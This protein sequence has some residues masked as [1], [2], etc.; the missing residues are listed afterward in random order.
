MLGVGL[1]DVFIAVGLFLLW[2]RAREGGVR[3]SWKGL[4]GWM[5]VGWGLS[6]WWRV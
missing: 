4:L 3:W 2:D 5:L 6:T 1:G